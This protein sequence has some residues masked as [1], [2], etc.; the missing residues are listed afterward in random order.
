MIRKMSQDGKYTELSRNTFSEFRL[1][2]V[3]GFFP[4]DTKSYFA[5]LR[6]TAP[7]SSCD[8]AG[9]FKTS[10]HIPFSQQ[11]L[12]T[13]VSHYQELRQDPAKNTRFSRKI[14]HG[15]LVYSCLFQGTSQNI[16]SKSRSAEVV[17]MLKTF[18]EVFESWIND[19]WS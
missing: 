19:F 14:L 5:I 11:G 15:I 1:S 10:R 16:L 2:S 3:I 7:R 8:A 13:H 17:N 4:Y 6:E 12:L 18:A 9:F